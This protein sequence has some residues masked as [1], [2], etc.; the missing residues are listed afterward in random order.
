MFPTQ[1]S[2]RQ[3]L[4]ASG[5]A[6]TAAVAGC[7]DAI[8][9]TGSNPASGDAGRSLRLTLSRSGETLRDGFVVD[10]SDTPPGWDEEAFEATLDGTAYTT[11]HRKPFFSA[12]DDPKYTERDGTYYRLGSVVIDETT[13]THPVLRLS[14]VEGADGDASPGGVRASA[15]PDVDRTA[16]RVAYFAA[17]ARGDEGGV[18]WGLVERS[19]YVYRGAEAVGASALLAEDGPERVTYREQAYA[20]EVSRERFHEPVYRATVEPVAQSPEGMEA[21]LRAKFVDARF[22][23]EDLS[24]EARDVVTAAAED[25]YGEHHPYSE[26]YRE[27]LSNLH[28]R[29][30][31]DGDIENDAGVPEDGRHLLRYD[32]VYYD[33]RLRFVPSGGDTVLRNDLPAITDPV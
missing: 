19:G 5:L 4:A 17:R 18:P 11:R 32:D 2:R 1:S 3:F 13:T 7:L 24:A 6:A 9:G 8:G 29:A 31:L 23:R 20:V 28:A 14:E 15:L 16:V 10:L 30:Y 12:S 22:A 21:V 25:G 27:A 33:Y 26:G